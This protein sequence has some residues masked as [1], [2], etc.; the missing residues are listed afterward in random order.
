M[1]LFISEVMWHFVFIYRAA[2]YHS[3]KD[4]TMSIISYT[5]AIKCQPDD[6]DAYFRRAEMYEEVTIS[7][8][9]MPLPEMQ[10]SDLA[11]LTR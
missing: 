11:N 6:D 7:V 3:Q 9:L 1:S 2:L 5:Q 4:I 10:I 8:C